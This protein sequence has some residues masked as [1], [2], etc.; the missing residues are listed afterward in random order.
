[1]AN[2]FLKGCPSRQESTEMLL[3]V[4]AIVCP[5]QLANIRTLE[6]INSGA[7]VGKLIPSRTAVGIV[8]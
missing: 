4:G 7:D 5:I 2:T 6:S 8:L 1:M 3:R